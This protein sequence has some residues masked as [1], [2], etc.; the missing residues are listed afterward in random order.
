VTDKLA[1]YRAALKELSLARMQEKQQYENNQ[2]ENSHLHFRRLGKVMNRF[3][4][5]GALEKFTVIQSQFQNHFNHQRHI[6]KRAY[7]KYLCQQSLDCWNEI[8][9]A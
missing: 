2:I 4:T 5:M 1:S 9:A 8:L 6:E 7:F 3:R